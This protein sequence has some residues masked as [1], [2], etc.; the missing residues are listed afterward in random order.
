MPL[1]KECEMNFNSTTT[2][3]TNQACE[4]AC[5]NS[6]MSFLKV[7]KAEKD[8]KEMLDNKSIH[9]SIELIDKEKQI[10]QT[11]I[12]LFPELKRNALIKAIMRLLIKTIMIMQIEMAIR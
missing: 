1:L 8:S 6:I 11:C 2:C 7:D 3:S 12:E 9:E 10:Y 4:N 5:D